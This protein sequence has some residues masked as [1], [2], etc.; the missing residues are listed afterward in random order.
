MKYDLALHFCRG[1]SPPY[2][3]TSRRPPAG[4]WGFQ[5]RRLNSSFSLCWGKGCRWFS[6]SLFLGRGC[7]ETDRRKFPCWQLSLP[8]IH[9]WFSTE[10]K[11]LKL[12]LCEL[13]FPANQTV[14]ALVSE[15]LKKNFDF[16]SVVLSCCGL[17][18]LMDWWIWERVFLR[19]C[20]PKSS[21]VAL[22]HAQMSPK[23]MSHADTHTHKADLLSKSKAFQ[24]HHRFFCSWNW[25]REMDFYF[26]FIFAHYTCKRDTM[27]DKVGSNREQ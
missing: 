24:F 13:L 1:D 7:R 15:A 8:V 14:I 19:L 23:V 22:I 21:W 12:M 11:Q 27:Q 4:S 26:G 10:E 2:I 25:I 5:G 16:H 18:S 3:R 9:I 17:C 6:S 20:I